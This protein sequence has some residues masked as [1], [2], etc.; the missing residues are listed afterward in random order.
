M[1]YFMKLKNPHWS[2]CGRFLAGYDSQSN[3]GSEIPLI[4]LYSFQRSH[5]NPQLLGHAML[6]LELHSDAVN[7]WSFDI[8]ICFGRPIIF[9]AFCAHDLT[10]GPRRKR[11][12]V[13]ESAAGEMEREPIDSP[14]AD[15]W[16]SALSFWYPN[17][18]ISSSEP[19][20]V[21][22]IPTS[23]CAGLVVHKEHYIKYKCAVSPDATHVI[24]SH[25]LTPSPDPQYNFT[26]YR[27]D[28]HEEPQFISVISASHETYVP[29]FLWSPDSRLCLW[30]R[31]SRSTAIRS[32]TYSHICALFGAFQL[33]TS[34]NGNLNVVEQRFYLKLIHCH[35]LKHELVAT[36]DGRL[37]LV[38]YSPEL[39][40]V[41]L[42]TPF[43]NGDDLNA[44]PLLLVKM[45]AH[46]RL[47]WAKLDCELGVVHCV[48]S[49][50]DCF[51]QS[52]TLRLPRASLDGYDMLR[53][54][55]HR[56]L[57][58]YDFKSS[59][60]AC[61]SE[62][63]TRVRECDRQRACV[64]PRGGDWVYETYQKSTY[65]KELRLP[66]RVR[67]RWRL[68]VYCEA[69][70]TKWT[71]CARLVRL[72]ASDALVV[73][74]LV[75]LA[76]AVLYENPE[77]LAELERRGDVPQTLFKNVLPRDPLTYSPR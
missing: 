12:R 68:R 3:N 39:L 6:S 19:T 31:P 52:C 49:S 28:P 63:S 65:E 48:V 1:L 22:T 76:R 64:N 37:L 20:V 46:F 72:G 40:H 25:Y 35:R 9:Y 27:F 15:R 30:N 24:V 8:G 61:V 14:V 55:D 36:F 38:S 50:Y 26:L 70:W 74:S 2:P 4:R 32:I 43:P 67:G 18:A 77:M 53:V 66:K 73:P 59:D 51:N 33:L 58:T 16:T 45:S 10:D 7:W 23:K 60:P 47:D 21:Q 75:H 62:E 54:P 13:S 57:C 41:S 29:Q 11:L 5:D 69:G 56:T 34:S 42:I 71:T 44:I 17:N